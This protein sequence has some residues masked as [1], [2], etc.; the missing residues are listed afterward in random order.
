MLCILPSL[1]MK[2]K[3]KGLLFSIKI[4]LDIVWYIYL[5]ACVL[6]LFI[7]VKHALR[8][9]WHEFNIPV[10][11]SETLER[12][13]PKMSIN[14][15]DVSVQANR[16]SVMIMNQNRLVEVPGIIWV[17]LQSVLVIAILSNLRKVFGAI[18][19]KEPFL[20]ENI[21]RLK[22][23]A[24]YIAL[25]F[26]LEL[27][28]NAVYYLALKNYNYLVLLSYHKIHQFHVL[29]RIPIQY[30]AVASIVYIMAEILRY[31]LE[32]KKENEEF[33]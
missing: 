21:I 24:L 4:G 23:T 29:W 11:L 6:M 14:N 25:F 22:I 28:Y 10:Q 1:K 26:P 17:V 3:N 7:S 9:G 15:S 20:H 31:G 27:C 8:E 32:L 19:R 18:Y 12:Y 2:V 13:Y 5:I 33:V 30:L 16:G